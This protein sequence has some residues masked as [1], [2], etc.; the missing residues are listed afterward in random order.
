[1]VVFKSYTR[2][3][4]FLINNEDIIAILDREEKVNSNPIVALHVTQ[5]YPFIG[6]ATTTKS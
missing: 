6:I 1:M 3:S 5:K 2:N 4:P